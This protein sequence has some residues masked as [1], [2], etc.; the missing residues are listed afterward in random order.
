MSENDENYYIGYFPS[1]NVKEIVT[2]A[3]KIK[4]SD[5]L[6]NLIIETLKKG[7]MYRSYRGFSTCRICD[8]MLG[9]QDLKYKNFVFP[10][11]WEHYVIEH[12][13]LPVFNLDTITTKFI[14]ELNN[15]LKNK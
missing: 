14:E 11:G 13:I 2:E 9:S 8:K 1:R 3:K 12:D 7:E 10:S 4:V 5:K 15:E 6:K